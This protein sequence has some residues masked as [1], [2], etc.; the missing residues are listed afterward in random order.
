[1]K[2]LLIIFAVSSVAGI[3]VLIVSSKKAT[4]GYQSV[5]G[6]QEGF[7]ETNDSSRPIGQSV[8]GKGIGTG[9][10]RFAARLRILRYKQS[11]TVLIHKSYRRFLRIS[12]RLV[13]PPL[14]RAARIDSQFR[15][16]F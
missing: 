14:L 9:T 8:S 11:L 1:M 10:G 2:P 13:V 3:V 6:F 16:S 4:E 5:T 15:G 7:K 12:N